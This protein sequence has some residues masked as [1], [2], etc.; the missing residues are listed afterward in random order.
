MKTTISL[1]LGC[2]RA[3]GPFAIDKINPGGSRRS[4]AMAAAA[5]DN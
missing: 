5:I 3:V 4:M 1:M 2:T